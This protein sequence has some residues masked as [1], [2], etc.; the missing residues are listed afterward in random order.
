MMMMVMRVAALEDV[1]DLQCSHTYTPSTGDGD[2]QVSRR[3]K[4]GLVCACY[5][6]LLSR[7]AGMS[8][9]DSVDPFL[10]RGGSVEHLP[11]LMRARGICLC[12]MTEEELGVC[13]SK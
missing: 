6:L 11:V 13:A 2:Q 3:R 4:A 12:R 5:Y 7:A 1:M 8:D 9:D 10:G